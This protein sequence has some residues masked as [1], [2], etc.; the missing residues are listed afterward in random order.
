MV[1]NDLVAGKNEEPEF[2]HQ[3]SRELVMTLINKTPIL[4]RMAFSRASLV[5]DKS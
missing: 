4:R 3:V 1:P 5:S 2:C